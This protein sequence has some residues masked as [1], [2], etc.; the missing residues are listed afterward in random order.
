MV[1]C[2]L[3]NALFRMTFAICK[4]SHYIYAH[5]FHGRAKNWTAQTVLFYRCEW[6]RECVCLCYG[7][8]FTHYAHMNIICAT[9]CV[10][11]FVLRQFI[12]MD[13]EKRSVC[14]RSRLALVDFCIT[15]S[16]II[17]LFTVELLSLHFVR[18]TF[19]VRDVLFHFFWLQYM[20]NNIW[21]ISI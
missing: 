16:T 9:V 15:H 1:D 7:H 11:V 13:M 20:V 3:S 21:L 4:T 18:Y 8:W 2:R 14:V 19:W 17:R 10:R 6:E 5:L 12:E